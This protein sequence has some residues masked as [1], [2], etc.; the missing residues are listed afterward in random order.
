MRWEMYDKKIVLLKFGLW[1]NSFFM[2]NFELFLEF[3]VFDNLGMVVYLCWRD[4][5]WVRG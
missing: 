1:I 2:E 5:G 3:R 4:R